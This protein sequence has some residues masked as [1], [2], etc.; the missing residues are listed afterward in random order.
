M[1]KLL[2]YGRICILLLC[3]A[4]VTASC[5]APR[6]ESDFRREGFRATLL[7]ESGDLELVAQVTVGKCVDGAPR[8]LTLTVLEPPSL[9][10]TVVERSSEGALT[11]RVHGIAVRTDVVEPMLEPVELL[12]GGGALRG[13]CETELDGRTVLY[14]QADSEQEAKG[15][16]FYLE[17]ESFAPVRVVLGERSVEVRSFESLS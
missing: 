6:V 3:V 17:P 2:V 14:A 9:A 15:Y 8:E 11:L 7:W 13:V 5:G 16:E 4:L 10:G 1:G 12:L